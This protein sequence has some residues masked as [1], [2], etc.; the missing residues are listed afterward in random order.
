MGEACFTIFESVSKNPKSI[1]SSAAWDKIILAS[2]FD[3]AYC[4][5][6]LNLCITRFALIDSLNLILKSFLTAYISL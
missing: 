4:S 5:V 6:L 3:L 2:L 1:S